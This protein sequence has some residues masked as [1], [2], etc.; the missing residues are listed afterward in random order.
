MRVDITTPGNDFCVS[1]LHVPN[2]KSLLELL[3]FY[4]CTPCCEARTPYADSRSLVIT[5]SIELLALRSP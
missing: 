5:H 2:L 4:L 1:F 3:I